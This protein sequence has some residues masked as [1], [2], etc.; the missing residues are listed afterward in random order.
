[1]QRE[2]VSEKVKS[3]GFW[4][5]TIDLPEGGRTPGH[6][7]LEF[8]KWISQ[9]IPTD[10][11]GWSV[12]DIGA[13]DGYFSFLCEGRGASRVLAIDNLQYV[14]SLRLSPEVG[15]KGFKVAK[16][17]LGSKVEYRVVDIFDLEKSFDGFDLVLCFGV[18][19]HL[20]N[21]AELIKILLSRTRRLLLFEGHFV[22]GDEDKLVDYGDKGLRGDPTVYC[23]ATIRWLEGRL[24]E[25]GF[26][27]VEVLGTKGDR[28]LLEGVPN[29][30]KLG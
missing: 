5:H 23:G 21:P 25:A 7:Q 29:G 22:K 2:V 19:Y 30:G 1:M 13:W 12:L 26:E 15:G 6:L 28:V 11:R 16:E 10:L 18:Y 24:K 4:W 17:L 14:R 27:H 20:K 3:V 8:Q 9:A